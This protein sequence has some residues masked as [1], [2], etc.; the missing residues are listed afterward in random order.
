ML[1]DLRIVDDNQL[2]TKLLFL[3]FV[4]P[5]LCCL[6]L[7]ADWGRQFLTQS[8]QPVLYREPESFG[9]RQGHKARDGHFTEV[10]G[11]RCHQRIRPCSRDPSECLP[12]FGWDDRGSGLFLSRCLIIFFLFICLEINL[13]SYL[14]YLYLTCYEIKVAYQWFLHNLS[15]FSPD[16]TDRDIVFYLNIPH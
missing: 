2:A 14:R 9:R 12:G 10:A 15:W 4:L 8:P 11:K 16:I 6:F 1:Q 7:R 13:H 3:P 5:L